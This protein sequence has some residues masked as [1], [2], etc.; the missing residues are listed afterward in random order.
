MQI[1]V[2]GYRFLF[3][4]VFPSLDAHTKCFFCSPGKS[5]SFLVAKFGALWGGSFQG[6]NSTEVCWGLEEIRSTEAGLG[7]TL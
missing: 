5:A 3:N 4:N 6:R 7:L 2:K 1:S